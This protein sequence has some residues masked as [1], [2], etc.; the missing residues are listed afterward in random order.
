MA[1]TVA[2][3]GNATYV[4]D[5][6]SYLDWTGLNPGDQSAFFK[7]GTQCVGFELW[8][9][10]DNDTYI[11]GS[12]DFSTYTHL[13]WWMMTTVLNE[14][15]TDANGGIQV[16]MSDGTNTG[17]WKVSG[18][19]TYPGGWWN[20]VIDTARA[21]D[22]GTKPTMSAITTIGFRFNL[23][24]S[25]KKVESL[26]MDSFTQSD[27]LTIKGNTS[28]QIVD[29][30]DIFTADS[31]TTLATGVIR[32]IGGTFFLTGEIEFTGD[33]TEGDLLFQAKSQ[34]VV[35]EDRPV[36]A[37][38]Y[39]FNII[40]NGT[41]TTQSVL[42]DKVG[43]AGVQGCKIKVQDSSQTPKFYID[44]KTD[45]DVDYFKIYGSTFYG[46]GSIS[47]AADATNVEVLSNSFEACS[48]VDPNTAET[49][50]CFFI[51]TSDADA[52]ILWNESIDI[53]SCSFIG[54]TTGAAIEMPS[55]A[56]TPYTYTNLVFSGN[57]Y[58]VLNSSG[59]AITIQNS[60]TSNA[61]SYEGSS[62]TFTSSFSYTITGLVNGSEVTFMERGTADDTGSDGSTTA[63]SRNFVTTNSWTPGEH[64]GKLLYITSGSDIGRY[65]VY[66]NT[67]TT[68]YLDT[69]LT[70]TD[71]SLD[72]ELY[73]ENDDTEEYHVENVTG[74]QAQY[75]YSY[76]A[77]YYVDILIHHVNYEPMLILETFRGV[78]L[79]N[80]NKSIPV[81][82][83]P[84]ANY[85]NP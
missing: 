79:S 50:Q 41:Q 9:S 24:A 64:Q 46:A 53:Q 80:S 16:Y 18:S 57:T 84:D 4:N 28:S 14:L 39:G 15:N 44:A 37:G 8:G 54:N 7:Y 69:E 40:D 55:A 43:T 12:W 83:I 65:Y 72:W 75:N 60:G 47:F 19:T 51:D 1:F 56:G 2:I 58:D 85:D 32:K 10:G 21:C 20:P 23:T 61:S 29:F 22:S 25:A 52:A 82:Q 78:H 73:D 67:A 33:G 5:G 68:L 26:W 6:E 42:G 81:S 17:Y 30:D 70:T 74:N 66:D 34:D 77:N 35:F 76:V 49:R 38:L 59:S 71:S 11:T 45:S 13:R 3:K 48:R 31:A 27:G 63:E 36:G 62:V